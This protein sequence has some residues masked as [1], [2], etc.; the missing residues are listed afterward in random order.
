MSYD[1]TGTPNFELL[2]SS[3]ILGLCLF[4]IP[5]SLYLTNY[6]SFKREIN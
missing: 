1:P 2:E 3:R 5:S 4:L 6:L